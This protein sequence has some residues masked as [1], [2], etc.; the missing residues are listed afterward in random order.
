[1]IDRAGRRRWATGLLGLATWSLGATLAGGVPATPPPVVVAPGTA[2]PPPAW[3]ETASREQ[4]L[5]TRFRQWCPPELAGGCVGEPVASLAAGGLCRL[6]VFGSLPEVRVEPGE[7]LRFH[8]A[9]EPRSARLVRAGVPEELAAASTIEWTAPPAPWPERCH[10]SPP[11]GRA[12]S[13]IAP[14]W[15]CRM[16]ERPRPPVGLGPRRAGG[17]VALAID[18]SEPALVS[19][20]IE[21]L[22][23]SEPRASSLYRRVPGRRLP[24]GEGTVDLGALPR[25]RYRVRLLVLDGAGNSR[26]VRGAFGRVP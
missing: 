13:P 18:L 26:V 19:G 23:R 15:S 6:L 22:G 8:L 4:W 12:R 5:A 24:A 16:I 21:P 10:S 14:V 9:S 17:R 7:R 1:M 2:G 20:C 3:I 25:G 11:S